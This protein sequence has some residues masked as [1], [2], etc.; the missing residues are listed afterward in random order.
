MSFCFFRSIVRLFLLELQVAPGHP[1]HWPPF[2]VYLWHSYDHNN[3]LQENSFLA[4][5]VLGCGILLWLSCWGSGRGH[6]L[7][8][9]AD[10][11]CGMRRHIPGSSMQRK[12][13]FQDRKPELSKWFDLGFREVEACFQALQRRRGGMTL[14]QGCGPTAGKGGRWGSLHGGH[15]LQLCV[16]LFLCAQSSS[17][18]LLER[19]SPVS[20][21]FGE[22]R[23]WS[24][25][26][27]WE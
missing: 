23:G 25:V 16:P 20:E 15:T 1:E 7:G 5:G 12:P 14:Q 4:L 22:F 17:K 18:T 11:F 19:S 24:R 27:H 8:I 9:K 10:L 13:E 21:C 26:G 2:G 3:H 6:A